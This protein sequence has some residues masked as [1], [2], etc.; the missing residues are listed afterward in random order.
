MTTPPPSPKIYHIIHVDRLASILTSKGLVSDSRLQG[1]T[2]IG[3]TIG[4]SHIKQRRLT[5]L[6]INSHPG[7]MVGN[8]VPF[9]FC[10]RSVM[11]YLIHMRN[12]QLAYQGGQG[13]IL[14]L[15]AD[16]QATINWANGAG[17]R[18]AF[19]SSNAGSRYFDDYSDIAQLNQLDWSAIGTTDWRDCKEAK[20]AEFLV[21]DGFPWTLIEKIGIIN[22]TSLAAKVQTIMHG[23]T[24]KPPVQYC[25]SW[26]Y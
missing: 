15:Q 14:H 1:I 2:G 18:W 12:P 7:L 11:L 20:Q 13:E 5:E 26:Y 21:E 24:Y 8:F 10:P 16:L 3:T 25:P 19:T 9:Y 22:D 17:L 6:P 23:Q 4:L